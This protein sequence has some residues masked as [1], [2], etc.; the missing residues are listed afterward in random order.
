MNDD[1]EVLARRRRKLEQLEVN[2]DHQR[3]QLARQQET[4][5]QARLTLR[6]KSE[7]ALGWANHG[8]TGQHANHFLQ[9][10]QDTQQ[11]FQRHM[12]ATLSELDIQKQ[13][14][15]HNFNRNYDEASQRKQD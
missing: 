2:Y 1:D 11:E 3:H 14:L 7:E 8:M 15:K 12:Q 13:Q 10:S 5:D 4:L 9:A 6:R